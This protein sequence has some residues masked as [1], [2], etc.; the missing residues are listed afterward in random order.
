M[1]QKQRLNS[2]SST[3]A[4]IIGVSDFISN[5][6]WARMFLEHQGY[7]IDENILYQDNESAIKIEVNGSKSCS[8][9]SRHIDMR[10]FF[11]KD[12]LESEGIKV[13]HCPTEQMVADFFTKPLQGQLFHFLKS[14]V[15][16]HEPISMLTSKFMSETQERVGGK[17]EER[18]S[19]SPEQKLPQEK[20]TEETRRNDDVRKSVSF[21]PDVVPSTKQSY[22]DVVKG[23]VNEMS[24]K[25]SLIDIYPRTKK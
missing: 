8:R 11:I 21:H 13:V 1:C 2:K 3:E 15:M 10:Y 14:I 4:E 19:V 25:Y 5:M 18:F 9:R 24:K 12:R 16:G 6:I 23:S 20:D 17:S 7:I 22:A